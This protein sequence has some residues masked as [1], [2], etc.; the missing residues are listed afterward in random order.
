MTEARSRTDRGAAVAAPSGRN[1]GWQ[2][3]LFVLPALL[4]FGGFVLLPLGASLYYG[5]TR[6]DGISPAE[7]VGWRNYL[8]AL[9]DGIYLRSYLNVGLYI[10]G[11]LVVEVAFG[12][13]MAVLLNAERRGF[14]LLR[15]LFFSPMV[16]SMVAAGLLW[17]FVYDLRF[18]LLNGAL[19]AVGLGT[20]TRAWLSDPKTALAAVTLVSGWKYA[21]FYM[22]IY[23]AALRRIPPTLYEAARL[24]GA[25]PLQQFFRVT[26]PL[27]RE[28]T[29]VTVLLCVTGG[30]AAF[31]LFFAMTGGG[32]FNATEIPTTWI[33]KQAFD[34]GRF[35]Y[36]V[37]LTVI[38]TVVVG[39]LSIAY[40]RLTQGRSRVEY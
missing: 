11:T 38:M 8:R 17:A 27:L 16:L 9:N 28:T 3:Y 25:G 4:L 40:L 31:D 34:R 2:A 35:G 23:L 29:I 24:D 22:I 5:F 14:G 26:L 18:G 13:V 20:L 7:W 32:P 21:G 19:E 33:V 15:V 1:D 6:W 37:A 30:F 36:G 39:L 10:L 12:L